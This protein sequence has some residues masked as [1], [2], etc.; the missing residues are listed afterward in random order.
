MR[1]VES[2]IPVVRREGS[3]AGSGRGNWGD[4][5]GRPSHAPDHP[6]C[7]RR[8]KPPPGTTRIQ[9]GSPKRQRRE[10]GW[11]VNRCCGVVTTCCR[12]RRPSCGSGAPRRESQTCLEVLPAGKHSADV[13][14]EMASGTTREQH[15]SIPG[16]H[17]TYIPLVEAYL[18]RSSTVVFSGNVQIVSQRPPQR[19]SH[20]H[21]QFCD[22]ALTTLVGPRA[23]GAA[24]EFETPPCPLFPV[25]VTGPPGATVT[26]GRTGGR[27]I[28][29]TVRSRGTFAI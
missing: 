16:T 15:G 21:G 13:S 3:A 24:A 27:K 8:S 12:T 5:A 29:R 1:P 23:G 20:D 18:Q 22:N 19:S 9:S 10:C 2:V 17:R 4:A 14:A 7:H 26:T 25:S 11:R 28:S 6:T